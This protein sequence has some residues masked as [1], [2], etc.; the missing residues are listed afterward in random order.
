MASIVAT[1]PSRLRPAASFSSSAG[2]A[3]V[4]LDLS[5]T[6]SCPSTRRL[7]VAKAETRCRAARPLDRSWLRRTV[8]PSMAIASSGS[9][10]EARTQSMKQAANRPGSI[11][12]IMMLS[13]RPEGTPQSNGR[14]RCRNSRWAFPSRR[15]R[16]S[17]RNRRSWRRRTRAEPCS[18]CAPRFRDFACPRSWQSGPREAATARVGRDGKA[19][20]PWAGSESGAPIDLAIPQ[21]VNPVNPSSEPCSPTGAAAVTMDPG[22][23]QRLGHPMSVFMVERDLS[24]ISMEGLASAQAA[25]IAQAKG[26]ATRYL[27]SIFAPEDGRCFCLFEA[28]DAEAVKQVNWA[29]G[30]PFK[31][32]VPAL[33]LPSPG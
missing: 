16:R 14:K 19:R 7:L 21:L 12:F 1:A 28:A 5:S 27:R 20:R 11:R 29:A 31:T 25:A 18:A 8:L 4:S 24:G 6:A 22:L 17:C 3:V 26:T 13:Q 23:P 15:W 30:L 10:H 33:D 9:G 2:M 32:V